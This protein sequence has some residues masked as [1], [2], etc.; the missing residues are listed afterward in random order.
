MIFLLCML[1]LCDMLQLTFEV[2]TTL[3]RLQGFLKLIQ[4]TKT[5]GDKILNRTSSN[6]P[7]LL[8]M[9]QRGLLDFLYSFYQWREKYD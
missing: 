6:S 9:V 2:F 1:R 8:I 3:C 5:Y 4:K 7:A